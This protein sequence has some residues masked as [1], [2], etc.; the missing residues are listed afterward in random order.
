[1]NKHKILND[2]KSFYFRTKRTIKNFTLTCFI[3]L[4]FSENSFSQA[5]RTDIYEEG[6]NLG[7]IPAPLSVHQI[8]GLASG[9][10][11]V[12]VSTT[13]THPFNNFGGSAGGPG[14][15]IS[16]PP[17]SITK[18]LLLGNTMNIGYNLLL[19]QNTPQCAEYTIRFEIQ[20]G[21]QNGALVA[22]FTFK[23]ILNRSASRDNQNPTAILN[24]PDLAIYD[25]DRVSASGLNAANLDYGFEPYLPSNWNSDYRN[26]TQSPDIWNR[27]ANDGS[28][29]F[30]NPT[31]SIASPQNANYMN[32]RIH[33]R[34]CVA[35]PAS[36]LEMYWTIARN[37][38][39]WAAD[40]WNYDR[41]GGSNSI[42]HQ[43]IIRPLGGEITIADKFDY[44]SAITKMPVAAFAPGEKRNIAH[45]WIVPNPEWYLNQPTF[46][47]QFNRAFG[48]PVICL[49]ARL[50]ETWKADKGN[51]NDPPQIDALSAN[52]NIVDY[53]SQHNNFATRNTHIMNSTNGYKWR[54]I[55]Q[56]PRTG[57]G[58]IAIVPQPTDPGTVPPPTN[59]IIIADTP[60]VVVGIDDDGNSIEQPQLPINL[61]NFG[62]LE[63]FMDALLW[64]RWIA[65][66]AQGENVEII[67][68]QVIRVTNPFRATLSNIILA[69]GEMGWLATEAVL[70]EDAAPLT[71]LQYH[72]S[73]GSFNP[74][75]GLTIGS[76]T[77]F[78]LNVLANPTVENEV[79]ENTLTSVNS[80]TNNDMV[81]V[82]PNPAKHKLYIEDKTINSQTVFTIYDMQGK[83]IKQIKGTKGSGVFEACLDIEGLTPGVYNL[84]VKTLDKQTSVRFIVEQ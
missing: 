82:F 44:T 51:A 21:G 79:A 66:G 35:T 39:P 69:E 49:L 58:V 54:P 67:A 48:T 20:K 34:S 30:E 60:T 73:V 78:E 1:M 61:A 47:I 5:S 38:E 74:E 8:F 71:N 80:L 40:W 63:L 77:H 83:L 59:I 75:T 56:Q 16:T 41:Q 29:Q 70:Y 46:P 18:V 11:D 2:T 27:K 25:N 24:T 3:L 28:T 57:G 13:N 22:D 53:V 68:E 15:M 37:W 84:S 72:F 6:G 10:Y 52:I 64:Q 26:I 33:N 32:V 36:E 45:P 23:I 76:P 12:K 17:G 19:P 43:G 65:G 42:F 7:T 14:A 4:V 50:Q 9:Y 81:K 55:G 31:H 62:H